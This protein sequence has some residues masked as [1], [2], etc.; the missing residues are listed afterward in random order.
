MIIRDPSA[1]PGRT[2]A[3][4]ESVDLFPTLV[5]LAGLAP[6]PS[7]APG[8]TAKQPVLCTVSAHTPAVLP[9]LAVYTSCAGR[10]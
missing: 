2:A 9:L 6:V 1:K 4:F 10:L 5:Q 7:C 8:P 3:L